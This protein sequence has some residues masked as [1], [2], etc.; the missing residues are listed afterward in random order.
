MDE[1]TVLIC[2]Y[3]Y[4][5]GKDCKKHTLHKVTQCESPDGTKRVP[6]NTSEK[7]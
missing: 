6:H 3:S 7:C 5:K 2:N 1:D 4:C